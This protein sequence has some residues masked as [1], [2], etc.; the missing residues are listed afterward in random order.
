[1]R[2]LYKIINVV[3]KIFFLL[4][5][6]RSVIKYD[7]KIYNNGKIKLGRNILI[8]RGCVLNI[9]KNSSLIIDDS[10]FIG[11][12]CEISAAGNIFIGENSTIQSRVNIFGDV[13]VNRDCIIS[14]NSYLSSCKHATS[15]IP[16][17]PIKIQDSI[18]NAS[19]SKKITI[20]EDCYLG[21][22]VFISPGVTIARGCIVGAN[23]CVINNLNPYSIVF[24]NPA[25]LI[26]YRYVFNP[27][28][29]ISCSNIK[30]RPY[31]YKGFGQWIDKNYKDDL[32]LM[33]PEFVLALN[34]KKKKEIKIKID[35][36]FES[37]LFFINT[38]EVI[39]FNKNTKELVFSLK[40]N[41]SDFLLFNCNS[42]IK[43]ISKFKI[44]AAE[45][46]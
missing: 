6:I 3:K 22:N 31:F 40:E 33:S 16:E 44:V 21:M 46:L 20:H 17:L 18:E 13:E 4:K 29:F 36:D 38:K 19:I 37:S 25:E 32:Y 9:K 39:F 41:K 26:S 24:G 1:M 35:V 14:P 30:D 45:V 42:F 27:P 23:S 8:E 11:K 28:E 15:Y 5:N 34:V 12:D 7:I 43:N 10:V 2:F